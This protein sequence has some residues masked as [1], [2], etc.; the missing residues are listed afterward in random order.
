MSTTAAARPSVLICSGLDP[1]GGAGFLADTRVVS[2]LGA[3]PVGIVTA[4]TVQST[5]GMRACHELDA[6]VVSDQLNALLTDIQVRA[7]KLGILGSQAVIRALG[8][9]LALTDAPVVWDPV[10][11]PTHGNV[12]FADLIDDALRELGP[13]LS[14]ITPNIAEL[15]TLARSPVTSLAEAEAAGMMVCRAREVAVLIKGGHLAGTESVDLLCHPGGVESL[16]TA[17]LASSDVHGTGCAL[18]AAIAAEL[19]LGLP[20]IEACRAAKRY[21]AERIADPS[22]PGRGAPAVL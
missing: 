8:A 11:G 13:H 17:R 9:N 10:L 3:R 1:S 18:S 14:L 15:S 6:D 7:V 4:L 19:A 22:R 20:L 2:D 21:V 16:R 12:S 5:Q